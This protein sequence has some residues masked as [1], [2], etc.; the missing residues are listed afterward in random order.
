MER[1][2]INVIPNPSPDSLFIAPILFPRT[3]S[4]I[5]MVNNEIILAGF[6]M[7]EVEGAMSSLAMV[8]AGLC[9]VVAASIFAMFW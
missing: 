2:K 4:P 9:T 5:T 1:H 6:Q 3:L 8:V 7:G